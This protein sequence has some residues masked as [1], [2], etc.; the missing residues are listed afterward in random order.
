LPWELGLVETHH[1]LVANGLRARVQLRVDGG[2]KT[3]RDVLLAAML[4]AD[5]FGFGSAMLVALGC[6]YARQCHKNTC[7]VG[8]ATQDPALRAKYKGTVE[9]AVAYFTFIANDVRRRLAAMGARSLDE[10][11]GRSDLLRPKSTLAEAHRAIDLSE[12]LRLP[13][14]STM[15][16]A[17]AVVEAHLDDFPGTAGRQIGPADRA[18][19]ARLAHNLVMQRAHGEPASCIQRRYTGSAGQSFGAFLTEGV[20]LDLTG[21]ANDYVGKS[22][23]GGRIVVRGAGGHDEPAIGNA[24]FYGARGGEAFVVGTAGERLAVRN[25]GAT[26]VVDGAGDHACEYMTRGT[27]VILGPTGRNLASGMSGGTLY[28]FGTLDDVRKRMGPT[29]C[30]IRALDVDS[31]EALVLASLLERYAEAT[32]SDRARALLASGPAA[33]VGFSVIAP[34][35]P[36]A[37][38]TELAAAG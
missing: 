10:V 31:A 12:I 8:I 29:E 5:A 21:E 34:K 15:S 25:S 28:A 3:G 32:D 18:V 33:F 27:V 35:R 2:F 26:V 19:G 37:K 7:P 23:E 22:M 4:G 17:P 16:D 20:E 9:E 38:P 30:S 6:I 11:H 1:A 24:S 13:E 36:V 14:A